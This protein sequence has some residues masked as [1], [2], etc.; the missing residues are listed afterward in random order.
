MSANSRSIPLIIVYTAFRSMR[1]V[2]RTSYCRI[3]IHLRGKSRIGIPALKLTNTQREEARLEN[4]HDLL[5]RFFSRL[6]FP[7][8]GDP[9][10]ILDC[11]YG[12]GEWAVDVAE[13]YEDCEVSTS[14]RVRFD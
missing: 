13:E 9:Q 11:G 5:K 8:I 2:I 10:K 4:Q 1:Y 12:R 14:N 3:P 7:G 6:Y